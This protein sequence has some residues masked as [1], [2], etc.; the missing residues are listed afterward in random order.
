[1]HA[2]HGDGYEQ[3]KKSRKKKTESEV[4]DDENW[5][6]PK[7]RDNSEWIAQY[8]ECYPDKILVAS[9]KTIAVKNQILIWQ[10]EAPEDK[11]I[12][13]CHLLDLIAMA[14]GPADKHF[15]HHQSSSTGP[16]WEVS[17]DGCFTR[18][19][20]TSST[21]LETCQ[22][23]RKTPPSSILRTSPTSKFW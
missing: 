21:I 3:G 8:D 10:K 14:Y 22:K 19:K 17:L 12:G 13:E 18:K 16:N 4:G 15:T 9:A 2:V 7:L 6:Q 1:M 5:V 23:T 20:S 11:I